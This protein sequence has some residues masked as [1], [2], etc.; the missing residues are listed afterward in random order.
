MVV[1]RRKQLFV[2]SGTQWIKEQIVFFRCNFCVAGVIFPGSCRFATLLCDE[3][4][5][6]YFLSVC[7]DL[8]TQN[9]HFRSS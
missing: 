3:W 6:C 4:S 8:S 9:R 1:V 7:K 5:Y 2:Q